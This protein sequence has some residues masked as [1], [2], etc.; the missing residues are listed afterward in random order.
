[1]VVRTYE[2]EQ[3]VREAGG[4]LQLGI[5]RASLTA[6]ACPATLRER[7]DQ[8][9]VRRAQAVLA[10]VLPRPVRPRPQRPRLNRPCAPHRAITATRRH[11]HASVP[12][13]CRGC[14]GRRRG[15]PAGSHAMAI[16]MVAA[17]LESWA[18]RSRV[19]VHAGYGFAIGNVAACMGD[20][21]A[22]VS[23]GGVGRHQLRRAAGAHELTEADVAPV[24]EKLRQA[25][26]DHIPVGVAPPASSTSSRLLSDLLTDTH[27][28]SLATH[29]DNLWACRGW[30]ALKWDTE[31][32]G[33]CVGRG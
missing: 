3:C 4:R 31:S 25:V 20:P 10:Q 7:G 18:A 33:V 16:A 21:E 1:M 27:A 5:G 30:E 32:R 23:P 29:A 28:A 24:K 2:Q 11:V 19:D 6:C 26:F 9:A 14:A 15:P 12:A 8:V 22:V 17:L 13:R